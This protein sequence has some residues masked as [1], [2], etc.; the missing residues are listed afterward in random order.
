LSIVEEFITF[1]FHGD[2]R[3]KDDRVKNYAEIVLSLGIFYLGYSVPFV[4]VMVS[5]Y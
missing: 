2:A 3:P 5:A 1:D 4:K